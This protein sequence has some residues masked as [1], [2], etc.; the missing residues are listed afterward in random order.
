[1][2]SNGP[3]IEPRPLPFRCTGKPDP[4]ASA[5]ID[6]MTRGHGGSAAGIAGTD[7]SAQAAHMHL[8]DRAR[9]ASNIGRRRNVK[10]TTPGTATVRR[11]ILMVAS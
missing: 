6:D 1:M 3:V 7:V 2:S 4:G 9:T 10:L 11:E 5:A 8:S